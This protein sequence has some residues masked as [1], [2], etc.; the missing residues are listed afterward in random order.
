ME[1][2]TKNGPTAKLEGRVDATVNES[3]PVGVHP[4]AKT[5]DT[6]TSWTDESKPRESERAMEAFESDDVGVENTVRMRLDVPAICAACDAGKMAN[7][8][9]ARRTNGVER[10]MVP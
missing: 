6:D 10:L 5:E 7:R 8:A 2:C 1:Y 9:T 4:E 3:P